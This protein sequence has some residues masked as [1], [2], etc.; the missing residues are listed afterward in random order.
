MCTDTID[1]YPNRPAPW[2]A[3]ARPAGGH[4]AQSVGVVRDSAVPG[5]RR[6]SA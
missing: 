1:P 6:A 2:P 3:V 4:V 5:W